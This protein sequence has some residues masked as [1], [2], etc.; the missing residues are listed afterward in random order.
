[1]TTDPDRTKPAP[2]PASTPV[3]PEQPAPLTEEP[4]PPPQN[5]AERRAAKHG[6][7]AGRTR[8]EWEQK[9]KL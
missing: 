7:H 3:K 4:P 9:P 2:E 5:R 6:S 1:M 8:R